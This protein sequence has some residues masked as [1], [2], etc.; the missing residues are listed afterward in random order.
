MAALSITRSSRD[1]LSRSTLITRRLQSTRS[2]PRSRMMRRNALIGLHVFFPP[3]F[4]VD[5][6]FVSGRFIGCEKCTLSTLTRF[7][8]GS[9]SISRFGGALKI[10]LFQLHR[11]PASEDL[12]DVLESFLGLK[13]YFQFSSLRGS[14]QLRRCWHKLEVIIFVFR[15]WPFIISEC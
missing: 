9:K 1:H 15:L 8:T 14:A 11:L 5:F 3:S 4:L 7:H 2:K 13:R 6:H 12:P 10:E